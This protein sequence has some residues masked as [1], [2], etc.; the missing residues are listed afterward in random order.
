[1]STFFYIKNPPPNFSHEVTQRDTKKK[2]EK[3]GDRG[4]E[5]QLNKKLLRMLHGAWGWQPL[6]STYQSWLF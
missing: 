5:K 3:T 4:K 6:I 1:M 2:V